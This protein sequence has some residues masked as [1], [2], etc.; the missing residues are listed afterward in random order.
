MFKKK[1]FK[2]I[3]SDEGFSVKILGRVGLKY[4]EGSR[5]LVIN[6]EVMP[7]GSSY[8]AVIE[9]DSIQAWNTPYDN[10]TIDE[11]KRDIIIDNVQR[12]L[13]FYGWQIKVM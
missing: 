11:V 13:Q 1:L 10:E 7:Y 9:K 3:T 2:V 4:S 12:A 5:T 8:D 6:S